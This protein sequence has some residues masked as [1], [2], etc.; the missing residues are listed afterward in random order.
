MCLFHHHNNN[1]N[2]IIIN[3]LL[4]C[5]NNRIF[6]LENSLIYMYLPNSVSGNKIHDEN[7]MVDPQI[8]NNYTNII[9]K[10]LSCAL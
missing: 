4:F 6:L 7:G 10:L 8:S 9:S 2:S 5:G 1:S 3:Q